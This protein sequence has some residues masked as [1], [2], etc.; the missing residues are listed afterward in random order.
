MSVEEAL[1]RKP[2]KFGREMGVDQEGY[3]ILDEQTGNAYSLPPAVYAIWSI[4]DGST[5]VEDI[6][7]KV[8]SEANVA[9]D[10]AR[11]IIVTVLNALA[12]VGLINW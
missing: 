11:E 12:D 6:S 10:Q 5:T 4:C 1:Q 7:A 8:S 3:V 9:L 2:M